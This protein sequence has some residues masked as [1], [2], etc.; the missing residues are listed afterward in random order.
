MGSLRVEPEWKWRDG[1]DITGSGLL[2]FGHRPGFGYL[3]LGSRAEREEAAAALRVGGG[4]GCARP[5]DMAHNKIPPRWLN[6][7]R[8]GQ[9]VAGNRDGGCSSPRAPAGPGVG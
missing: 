3:D 8:R 1:A 9:P 6:C 4:G 2:G 5:Q 7:P